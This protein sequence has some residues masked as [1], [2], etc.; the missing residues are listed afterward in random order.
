[1]NSTVETPRERSVWRIRAQRLLDL[2]G[3]VMF[4]LGA[5]TLGLGVILM[6][7][8]AVS[9]VVG[10]VAT[11]VAASFRDGDL[12]RLASAGVLVIPAV[13]AAIGWVLAKAAKKLENAGERSQDFTEDPTEIR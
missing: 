10:S 8:A 5:V 13:L 11:E 12:W 4:K 6:A 1:M 2:L 7:V 9:W 3:R